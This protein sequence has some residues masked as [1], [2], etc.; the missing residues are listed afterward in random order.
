M[1]K[2]TFLPKF[3][4]FFLLHKIDILAP[5]LILTETLVTLSPSFTDIILSLYLEIRSFAQKMLFFTKRKQR[6]QKL[7]LQK[8][9]ILL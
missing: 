5:K 2:S 3:Q 4:F 9:K 1:I 7:T 8:Q 6:H